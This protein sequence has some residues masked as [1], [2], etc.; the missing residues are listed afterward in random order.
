MLLS[1][2]CNTPLV[3]SILFRAVQATRHRHRVPAM[4]RVE[5]SR[6][7]SSAPVPVTRLQPTLPSS[8]D[9]QSSWQFRPVELSA[10][11]I[12]RAP[13]TTVQALMFARLSSPQASSFRTYGC[14]SKFNSMP[15]KAQHAE[16]SGIGWGF[17]L[18]EGAPRVPE[19][20]F[21]NPYMGTKQHASRYGDA[22]V[23]PPG[24]APSPLGPHVHVHPGSS[25]TRGMDTGQSCT[26]RTNK[27]PKSCS[28]VDRCSFK[29]SL[30]PEHGLMP[31]MWRSAGERER[32]QFLPYW[33][34]TDKWG[35]G[36]KSKGSGGVS[37]E[38]RPPLP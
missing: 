33:H 36:Y 13:T 14:M 29:L 16:G 8:E 3:P 32:E 20:G 12:V 23:P 30:P 28:H 31:G 34:V 22:A 11:S 9:R 27:Q 4:S 21:T 38:N 18:G 1:L 2:L 35:P 25:S 24:S 10:A 17:R 7:A 37:A 15:D 19:M 5:S 26:R 6:V